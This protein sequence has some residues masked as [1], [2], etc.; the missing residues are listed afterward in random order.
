MIEDRYTHYLRLT[1]EATAAAVLT[2]AEATQAAALNEMLTVEQAATILG[3]HV[4]TIRKRIKSGELF[5]QRVGRAI[6]I[7]ASDL[8]RPEAPKRAYRC[9]KFIE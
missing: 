8:N 4:S 5:H 2:L 3:V 7:K 9:L 1:G 6:R